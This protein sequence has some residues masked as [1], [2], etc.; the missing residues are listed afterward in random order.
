ML[1]MSYSCKFAQKVFCLNTGQVLRIGKIIPM[2][3]PDIIINKV[4]GWCKR[5]KMEH[6]RQNL[7]LVNRNKEPYDWRNY[8]LLKYEVLVE[9]DEITH[10]EAAADLPGVER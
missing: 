2:V 8:K 6:Y 3:A 5:S 4:N 1:F 9:D 10:P 7:D